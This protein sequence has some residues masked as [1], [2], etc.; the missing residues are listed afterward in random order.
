MAQ[1]APRVIYIDESG[2][3]IWT[4]RTRGRARVGER[5]VR[6]V[7]GQR[8][9]SMTLILAILV[10]NGI[11]KSQF[12]GGGTTKERFVTF[13]HDLEETVGDSPCIFVLDNAPCHRGVQVRNVEHHELRYICHPILRCSRQSKTHFLPGKQNLKMLC[14]SHR[15]EFLLPCRFLEWQ[16]IYRNGHAQNHVGWQK[17]FDSHRNQCK[18]G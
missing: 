15:N 5:A 2:F 4:Q 12:Y 6:V 10:T 3:N 14:L 1:F 13:L 9:E 18:N 7:N 17:K 11:E 8:G 16:S